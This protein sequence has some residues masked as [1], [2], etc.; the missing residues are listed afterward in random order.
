MVKL[1][2]ILQRPKEQ[3]ASNKV[4]IEGKPQ[5]WG[6]SLKDNRIKG[7]IMSKSVSVEVT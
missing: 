6:T 4:E 2:I 7:M 5:S 1:E 3:K